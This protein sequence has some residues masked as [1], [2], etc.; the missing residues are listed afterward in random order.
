MGQNMAG[1]RKCKYPGC[2]ASLN[3]YNDG[4]YCH[5][6]ETAGREL[7]AKEQD[8]PPYETESHGPFTVKEAAERLSYSVRTVRDMLNSGEMA[9]SRVRPNGKWLISKYEV[10]RLLGSAKERTDS[11]DQARRGVP[12]KSP[13]WI[14]E[15]EARYGRLPVLPKPL[16]RL[17][18][19]GDKPVSKDSVTYYANIGQWNAIKGVPGLEKKW[20]EYLEWKGEDPDEYEYEVRKG[21]PSGG[22]GPIRLTYRPPR[23]R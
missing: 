16:Q 19:S 20:R 2:N 18:G 3:Q 23:S 8:K 21:G 12:A 10:D 17:G 9:G 13:N 14:E 4:N 15:Y 5:P 6:H 22:P 1:K 7:E 11:V